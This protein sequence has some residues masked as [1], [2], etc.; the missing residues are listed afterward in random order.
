LTPEQYRRVLKLF[1][2][3]VDLDPRGRAAF[4][5]EACVGE[6][7]LRRNVE[8]MLGADAKPGG[9]LELSSGDLAADLLVQLAEARVSAGTLLGPY[10][11]DRWLGAGGTAQVFEA[12]DTRLGRKVAVKVCAERFSGRFKREARAISAL[13]HPTICAVYDIGSDYLVTELVEG[14]TLRQ[15]FQHALPLEQGLDI[16]KQVLKALSVAH[17]AGIVHRDLKPENVMV[18]FDGYVKVLDFGLA[19]WVQ[20][21]GLLQKDGSVSADASLPGQLVGTVA[22][23][24]P[25][26]IEGRPLDQRSDLFAFGTVLY[27]MLTGRHPWVCRR[28]STRSTRSCIPSRRRSRRRRPSPR[29]WPPSRAGCCARTGPGAIRRPRRCWTFSRDGP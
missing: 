4:L 25:E 7:D 26:Q 11:I 23:M 17:R 2:A 10:R 20:G 8:A 1:Q 12:E 27:E 15:W 16:A 22:Y 14:E 9:L 13:N 28:P 18:R 29:N 24:S 5:A 19:K 21:D 3:A 6:D